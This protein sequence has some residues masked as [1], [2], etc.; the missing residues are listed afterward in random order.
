MLDKYVNR[1]QPD[2]IASSQKQILKLLKKH[3]TKLDKPGVLVKV[4]EKICVLEPTK[5]QKD[6][7]HKLI[8]YNIEKLKYIDQNL[9]SGKDRYNNAS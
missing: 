5:F 3:S 6:T 1:Q 9:E 2:E 8:L 4:D 7:Y